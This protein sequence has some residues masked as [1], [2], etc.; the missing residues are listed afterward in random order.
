MRRVEASVSADL[1][2]TP[3]QAANL[4]TQASEDTS[5]PVRNV[6]T[7]REN[8]D[9]SRESPRRVQDSVPDRDDRR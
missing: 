7:A 1:R 5:Q 8:A 3:V 9:A 2:D 6:D 4:G